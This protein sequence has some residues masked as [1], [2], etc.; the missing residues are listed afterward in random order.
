MSKSSIQLEL[1][2]AFS[3]HGNLISDYSNTYEEYLQLRKINEL[4]KQLSIREVGA[5]L[6]SFV[7][8]FEGIKPR[9]GEISD[10]D[11]EINR[12]DGRRIELRD[13]QGLG[14]L[15]TEKNSAFVA[16]G[17]SKDFGEFKG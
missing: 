10:L 14:I 2:D 7:K 8:D 12:V 1:L 5:K 15:N 17:I 9:S 6:E 4:E 16:L 3:N 13:S 11:N